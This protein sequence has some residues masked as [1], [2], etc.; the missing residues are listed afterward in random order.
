MKTKALT[1]TLISGLLITVVLVVS[2][3]SLKA[4]TEALQLQWSKTYYGTNGV[5]IQ[6]S[7]GGY[8]I[9]GTNASSRLFPAEERAPTLIKTDPSGQMEWNTTFENTGHTFTNTILQ[10]N[11]GGYILSGS[12]ISGSVM[13]AVYSGWL[14]KTDVKGSVQW[15]KTLGLPLERCFTIQAGDGN[16]VIVGNMF[17]NFN[18]TDGALI[19][20]DSNGNLLWS[21]TFGGNSTYMLPM[22]GV[23]ANDGCYVIAGAV[24]KA[25]WLAKTDVNGNFQWSKTH[26]YSTSAC[27]TDGI[28]KTSDGGYIL[29]GISGNDYVWLVKTDSNG[30]KQWS[31]TY[32]EASHT[33]LL[34]VVQTSDSS[35]V[36]VGIA[37]NQALIVRVDSSGKLLYNNLYGEIGPNITSSG[38]SVVLTSDGGYAVAGRLDGFAF[39]IQGNNIVTPQVGDHTWLAKFAAEPFTPTPETS[40]PSPFSTTILVAVI[41]IVGIVVSIGLGLLIYLLK[42]R[43]H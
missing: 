36:A 35:Y 18:G 12:S 28:A 3:P 25:G 13:S 4:D 1:L 6:T 2:V 30:N 22:A 14:I 11:D 5:A 38:T 20:L 17:N 23:E 26:Q 7:D 42:K 24:G 31:H 39:N 29:A 32:P 37:N 43:R 10:T 16:F 40:T 9:A 21:K 15:N 33:L 19:K 27:M 8:A 34:S 41:I